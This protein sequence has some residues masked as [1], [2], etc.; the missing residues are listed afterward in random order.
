MTS[1]LEVY[2]EWANNLKFREALKRNPKAALKEAGFEL[3]ETDFKT[4][5][6]LIQSDNEALDR[7][8]NK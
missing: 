8:I 1:L 5:Q 7:R 6:T 4:I 3:S 2:A